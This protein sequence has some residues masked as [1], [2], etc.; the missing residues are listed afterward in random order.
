MADGLLPWAV[1]KIKKRSK[2]YKDIMDALEPK[3]APKPAPKPKPKNQ[4][5]HHS[6]ADGSF[7]TSRR[8]KFGA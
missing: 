2:A 4:G 3:P 6:A 1:K 5:P 8:K 7:L